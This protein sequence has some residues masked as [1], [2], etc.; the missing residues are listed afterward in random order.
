M[1]SSNIMLI[2]WAVFILNV[3]LDGALYLGTSTLINFVLAIPLIIARM[4]IKF[5]HDW[6]EIYDN[7][8]S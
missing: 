4:P 1:I 3:S 6:E 2:L 7:I 8:F 5:T